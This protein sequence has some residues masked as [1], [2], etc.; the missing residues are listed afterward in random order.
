MIEIKYSENEVNINTKNLSFVYNEDQLPLIF[1]LKSSVSK[2]TIWSVKLKDNMWA[3]YPKNEIYDVVVR[4]KNYNYITQYYWDVFSHGT[5]FHKSLWL[6]CKKIINNGKKPRGLV[7]GTHDGEFGEW[8]PVAKNFL[9]DMLLVEGSEKQYN[10]L[11][12]NYKNR[13]GILTKYTLVTPNGGNVE[14]FEGGLGYT[15]TIVE[16]VIRYWEKETVNSTIKD[17]IGIND[18]LESYGKIDWLH[19]DVEGLDAKLLMAIKTELP[20]FIIFEDFNL[21]NEEKGLIYDYLRNK[22]FSLYSDAGICMASR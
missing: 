5:I 3:S 4:D 2:E 15:N 12:N 14:F 11:Y 13:D 20:N 1:E 10:K 17:S 21:P 9:S 16:R 6:Y 18:L 22:N 19:L 7:I 8:V